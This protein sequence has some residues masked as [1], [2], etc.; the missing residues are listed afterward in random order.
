MDVEMQDESSDKLLKGN[1]KPLSQGAK[2]EDVYN[3][4]T[5]A[6]TIK[7]LPGVLSDSDN[8][9]ALATASVEFF[10]QKFRE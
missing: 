5:N 3:F 10:R 2:M 8:Y 9:A 6:E 7:Y 4:Q 1:L